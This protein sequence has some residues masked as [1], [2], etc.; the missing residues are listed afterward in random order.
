[1][2]P[3]GRSSLR[4]PFSGSCR[5]RRSSNAPFSACLARLPLLSFFHFH[6]FLLAF[7]LF[8]S[9]RPENCGVIAD[10]AMHWNE[11]LEKTETILANKDTAFQQTNSSSSKNNSYSS[12]FQKEITLPSRLVYYLNKDSESPYHILDTRTRHQ[13]KH[14][15]AVHLAQ[16]SFKIEA[17]G[18][19]FILDLSLNNDL[20]SSDY[21]EIHYEDDK[22][23][24]S[25]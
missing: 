6:R 12:A 4:Q 9:G 14:N 24:Y 10:T 13:Q 25:K 17:F 5:H 2:K 19:K 8:C 21:V 1:M 20:L 16:A 11:T 23:Q 7:L 18:S 15:K 22:P 3:P